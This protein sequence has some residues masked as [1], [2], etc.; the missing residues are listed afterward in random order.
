MANENWLG[1]CI[2]FTGIE[3]DIPDGVIGLPAGIF[4]ET[5]VKSVVVFDDNA[6]TGLAEIKR[7]D[8]KGDE[9]I[10]NVKFW[11]G[12]IKELLTGSGIWIVDANGKKMSR[13]E[14]FNS[15]SPVTGLARQ[16]DG[17]AIFAMKKINWL[18]TGGGVQV[19][20]SHG[21]EP[22]VIGGKK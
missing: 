22:F 17:L 13:E 6:E 20:R 9:K 3:A 5:L 4:A 1:D 21:K 11:E 10:V 2:P 7:V 12:R 16:T 14:W 15:I 19:Q 18:A 8:L